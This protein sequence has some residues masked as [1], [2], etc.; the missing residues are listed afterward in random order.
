MNKSIS[1][2]LK[3]SLQMG[4]VW[5]FSPKKKFT[6]C[7]MVNS[8]RVYLSLSSL[9]TIKQ[10]KWVCAAEGTQKGAC[11]HWVMRRGWFSGAASTCPMCLSACSVSNRCLRAGEDGEQ[12]SLLP[13]FPVSHLSRL[14]TGILQVSVT[15]AW[16]HS[17]LLKAT[18]SLETWRRVS[19]WWQACI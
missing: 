16:L 17:M 12:V 19:V 15:L 6:M 4:L 7:Q 8:T 11:F 10:R 13:Q 2:Q 18:P 1:C 9:I 3:N 14:L 5:I